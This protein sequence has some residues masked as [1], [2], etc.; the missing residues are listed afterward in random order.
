MSDLDTLKDEA[1]T[2]LLQSIKASATSYTRPDH[3]QALAEAYALVAD[4]AS[5]A[6]SLPPPRDAGVVIV[7]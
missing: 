3:L 5:G 1:A 7:E 2:A 4:S 6:E